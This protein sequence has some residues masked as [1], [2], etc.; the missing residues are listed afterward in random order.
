MYGV[1]WYHQILCLAGALHHIGTAAIA[2]HEAVNTERQQTQHDDD[3]HDTADSDRDDLLLREVI[4]HLH[5]LCKV[6]QG[7]L[8]SIKCHGEY[9]TYILYIYLSYTKMNNKALFNE[10]LFK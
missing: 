6:S 8:V 1:R 7:K 9:F 3:H 4:L 5:D 2:T 10:Q